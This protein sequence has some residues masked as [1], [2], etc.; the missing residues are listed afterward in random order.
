MKQERKARVDTDINRSLVSSRLQTERVRSQWR[1]PNWA[2]TINAVKDIAVKYLTDEKDSAY[3]RLDLEASKMQMQELE[4]IRVADS[5]EKIPEIENQFKTAVSSAFSQDSWGKQWLKERGDLFFAANSRDVLRAGIAKQK[6]LSVLEMNKTIN[7]FSD[8][9]ATSPLDKAM[10]LLGD[11]TKFIDASGVLSPSEKQSAKNGALTQTMRRMAD[12]NPET[13]LLMLNDKNYDWSGINTAGI[14]NLAEARQSVLAKKRESNDFKAFVQN[15]TYNGLQYL[16]NSYPKT[17]EHVFKSLE[18]ILESSPNYKSENA[19]DVI[20][21][22]T[23]ELLDFSETQFSDADEAFEK[24]VEL[25][26]RLTRS[27]QRGNITPEETQKG[28]NDVWNVLQ[29]EAVQSSLGEL[30]PYMKA[31]QSFA[32]FQINNFP[33]NL[34]EATE[35]AISGFKKKAKLQAMAKAG[36][37]GALDKLRDGDING[38]KEVYNATRLSMQAFMHPEIANK[39]VGDTIVLQ[40]DILGIIES[41]DG[42]NIIVKRVR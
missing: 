23:S 14:R 16:K 4:D 11:M 26:D 28:I 25:S 36:M 31:F 15:P 29:D 5:N 42:D 20:S 40:N 13:A 32:K 12:E 41:M 9:I 19:Y 30:S 34:S 8:T 18:N 17:K 1:E 22:F 37:I 33:T 27:N 24:A 2:N 38:A 10:V 7:T 6:E 35:G 39:K 21:E 3:K